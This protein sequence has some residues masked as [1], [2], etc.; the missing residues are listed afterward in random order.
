MLMI[1]GGII[2]AII[3]LGCA[4]NPLGGIKYFVLWPG[5]VLFALVSFGY[6]LQP[7]GN[8]LEISL[9]ITTIIVVALWAIDAFERKQKNAR[10]AEWHRQNKTCPS[11]AEIVKA[12]ASVCKHCG[13]RF[14]FA[15]ANGEPKTS[16]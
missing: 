15:A 13:H 7:D 5:L 14:S 9:T 8:S 11:C 16:D 3:L 2:L 10:A 4:A 1:A 12:Q 6:Y